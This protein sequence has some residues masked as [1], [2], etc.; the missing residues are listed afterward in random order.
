MLCIYFFVLFRIYIFFV[1]LHWIFF[2]SSPLTSSLNFC[3]NFLFV[4][5]SYVFLIFYCNSIN[6]RKSIFFFI[7]SFHSFI[8]H[9]LFIYFYFFLRNHL[10][11]LPSYSSSPSFLLPFPSSPSRPSYIAPFIYASSVP[12]MPSR[13]QT[14]LLIFFPFFSLPF[15]SSSL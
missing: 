12:L 5:I 9:H 13:D 4:F 7:Y 2:S 8:Y 10:V 15:F 14:H 6:L 1:V 3:I 11:S